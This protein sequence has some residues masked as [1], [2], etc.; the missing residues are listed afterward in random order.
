MSIKPYVEGH[1]THAS[2]A[3]VDLPLSINVHRGQLNPLCP[4]NYVPLLCESSSGALFHCF[5]AK[6]TA[7]APDRLPT[8]SDNV[9]GGDDLA[10]LRSS[11]P[12]ADTEYRKTQM[13]TV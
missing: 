2:A 11:T 10:T 7:R 5:G 13:F 6:P 9:S 1:R 8:Q 12:S 4:I 3:T